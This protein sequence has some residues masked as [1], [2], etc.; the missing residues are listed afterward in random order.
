MA[1]MLIY[2][3]ERDNSTS[4]VLKQFCYSE[5]YNVWTLNHTFTHKYSNAY[6][7]NNLYIRC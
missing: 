4:T 3:V 2:E 6:N 7:L 5:Q 1:K